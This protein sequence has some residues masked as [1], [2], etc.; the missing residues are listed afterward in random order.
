MSKKKKT[1]NRHV[2]NVPQGKHFYFNDCMSGEEKWA[3]SRG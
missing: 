2:F 3:G 1:F